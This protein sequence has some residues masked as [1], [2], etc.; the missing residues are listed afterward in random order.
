LLA[1]GC[2]YELG[3]FSSAV[4]AAQAYDRYSL[5]LHGL[6]ART[7]FPPWGYLA[8]DE[9]VFALLEAVQRV[10]AAKASQAGL[11]GSSLQLQVLEQEQS[12]ALSG[13]P[14]WH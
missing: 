3:P 10:G 12:A 14:A 1:G 6:A 13:A 5:L 8:P 7:N 2:L 11:L 4:E 9:E